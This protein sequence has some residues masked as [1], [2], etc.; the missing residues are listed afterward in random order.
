MYFLVVLLAVGSIIACLGTGALPFAI[1]ATVL[2][3]WMWGVASNYRQD[4]MSIPN[5]TVWVSI[6][7]GL[8]SIALIVVGIAIR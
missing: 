5:Y 3:V 2:A 1:G 4:P 8:S 7:A 6:L